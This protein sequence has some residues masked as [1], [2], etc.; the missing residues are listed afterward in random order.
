MIY[1]G[2][3]RKKVSG[4]DGGLVWAL[5]P[6]QA[7]VAQVDKRTSLCRIRNRAKLRALELV[8]PRNSSLR[9]TLQK[10][11]FAIAAGN[12]VV[13]EDDE[14]GATGSASDSE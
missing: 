8:D 12:D 7:E 1:E 13:H 10:A 3:R 2:G 4:R 9:N 5:R 6:S 14:D 11:E